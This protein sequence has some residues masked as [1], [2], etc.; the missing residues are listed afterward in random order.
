MSLRNAML[1]QPGQP[2]PKMSGIRPP[3]Q[4]VQPIGTPIQGQMQIQAPVQAPTQAPTQPPPSPFAGMN[5]SMPAPVQRPHTSVG[6]STQISVTPQNFDQFR[7]FGDIVMQEFQR[8]TA[9]EIEARRARMNQ[10]LINR[11]LTPGS[12]GY[13]RE[14]DRFMRMENDMFNTA[15]RSALQEG[16]A[17]QQQAWSQGFGQAQIN[18]GLRQA[19]IGADAS[20]Y[21]A[22]V[23]RAGALERLLAGL[24][25]QE[26]EFGRTFG[27]GQFRDRRDFGEDARRFG[28]N[29]GEDQFRDRRDFG[30]NT[31]RFNMDF[32]ESQR[33]FN[34][35]FGEGQ[36][37][38]DANRE[39]SRF[40]FG[41][42]MGFAREQADFG[43]LMDLF[44]FGLNAAGF[45]NQTLNDDYNRAFNATGAFMPNAPFVPV[46]VGGAYDARTAAQA[47]NAQMANQRRNSGIGGLGALGSAIFGNWG[48]IFS[49]RNAKHEIKEVDNA[50]QLEALRKVPVSRWKYKGEDR[51]HIGPMA[52]DFGEHING[53]PDARVIH[54]VDAIGTLIAS[55]QALADKVDALEAAHVS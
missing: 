31:R 55:V 8:T 4:Q 45:N 49:D 35:N 14:M 1:Q 47:A 29:F 10:D 3:P 25:Q 37:Q 17:A 33:Q 23:G 5:I 46:N 20:M 22:D 11:G 30:E 53:E 12:E 43:N 41:E 13:E 36:R 42:N 2:A 52:Q 44:G 19:Q 9:P 28:L 18:A 6:G 7:D 50:E 48:D 16:L 40:F 26:S 51:E 32:G 39:D 15:Q 54:P 21:N 34:Q 24:A 27:E 38:F